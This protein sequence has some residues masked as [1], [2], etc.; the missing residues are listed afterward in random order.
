MLVIT[1]PCIPAFSILI[2]HAVDVIVEK[3]TFGTAFYIVIFEL[4]DHSRFP[5]SFARLSKL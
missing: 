2:D 3:R 5:I 4:I 1:S